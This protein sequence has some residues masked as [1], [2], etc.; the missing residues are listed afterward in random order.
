MA[1]KPKSNETKSHTPREKKYIKKVNV[2]R[3]FVLDYEMCQKKLEGG[4]YEAS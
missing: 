3:I 4:I 2:K 1:Q